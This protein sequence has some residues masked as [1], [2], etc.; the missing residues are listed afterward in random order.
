MKLIEELMERQRKEPEIVLK[1]RLDRL[2]K[3]IEL[4]EPDR[5]PLILT[6]CPP[7]FALKHAG[8]SGYDFY[9]DYERGWKAIV[10]FVEDYPM[11]SIFFEVGLEGHVL[12]LAFPEVPEFMIATAGHITGPMHDILRDKYTK[13]PGRELPLT[14]PTGQFLGGRF[15][16]AEEYGKL[17]ENPAEF[18]RETILPRAFESLKD[19]H[20]SRIALIKTGIELSKAINSMTSIASDLTKLG[21]PVAPLTDAYCPVDFIA[22]FLR[23][24]TNMLIDIYRIPDKVKAACEV[25]VELILNMAFQVK[26]AVHV[27]I[28]L[29]LNEMLPPKTYNELYWPYLK[30]VIL[31]LKEKGLTIWVFFEG[32]HEPHLETLLELPKSWG[33]AW[34]EKTDVRKAKRVLEGHTCIMGG[35]PTN[36]LVSGTPEKIEEYVKNLIKDV[37][38]GGGFIISTGVADIPWGTSEA[39][40]RALINA[41]L[42]YGQH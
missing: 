10:K 4:K 25:L 33:I 11:D 14:I 21:Y 20:Q 5:V 7:A 23:H 29:H 34:F 40:L 15:M 2:S 41:V 38:P 26:N 22:D 37:A 42:K 39:N 32:N 35:F 27:F 18:I 16:E 24:V 28:P 12:A 9:Y 17:I 8:V 19:V 3:T 1:E 30:K 31:S 13:F 6:G 36:L